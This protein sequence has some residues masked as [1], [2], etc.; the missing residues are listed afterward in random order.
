[1]LSAHQEREQVV[2]RGVVAHQLRGDALGLQEHVY[3]GRV[4]ALLSVGATEVDADLAA[5][6]CQANGQVLEVEGLAG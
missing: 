2:G 5:A 4:V 6:A 1:M 3:G